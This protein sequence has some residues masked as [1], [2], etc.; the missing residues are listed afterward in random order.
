M[1]RRLDLLTG[2]YYDVSQEEITRR[3]N[4]VREYME[5]KDISVLLVLAS[6]K[7]GYR[8]WLTGVDGTER[9]SESCFVIPKE[10]DILHVVGNKMAE[11]DEETGQPEG[12]LPDA[13]EAFGGIR[14]AY[15]LSAFTIRR[16]MEDDG[17]KRLGLI[18]GEEIRAGLYDYLKKFLPDVEWV[19]ATEEFAE[20]KAVK[21]LEE[22][23]LIQ[24]ATRLQEQVL[25]GL[26]GYLI[27]GVKEAEA[28]R[29]ARY[30]ASHL[31][32]GG[33]DTMEYAQIELLSWRDR[34]IP[35][36][37][38]APGREMEAGDMVEIKLRIRGN[39]GFYGFIARR[40]SFGEPA[41]R[42]KE[43][44][45]KAILLQEMAEEKIKPGK[46][47]AQIEKEI[48]E[49]AKKQGISLAEK[50]F[51]HG[52]GYC[53][54]EGPDRASG[55]RHTPLQRGMV[56]AVEPEVMDERGNKA[57]CGDVYGVTED[58]VQRMSKS[59]RK[60]KVL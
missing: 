13:E 26:C 24:E 33:I 39:S 52:I 31:G 15:Q 11:A 58:G 41:S 18:H 59:E 27:P 2:L 60:I 9:P 6:H 36:P 37:L 57:C 19:D 10:G 53:V 8:Q 44:W 48:G 21:S 12:A 50:D 4:L 29:Y 45:H 16:M 55:L 56:L 34:Q 40:F 42:E 1:E 23:R 30:L 25:E 46:T 49:E 17:E 35:G 47:V 14:T 5:K 54:S 3:H 7:E 20:R 28:V 32:S 51:I 43:I 38:D 22:Q